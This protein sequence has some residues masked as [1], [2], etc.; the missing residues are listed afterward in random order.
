SGEPKTLTLTLDEFK[1]TARDI[2]YQRM[3]HVGHGHEDVEFYERLL[4]ED[5]PVD[6]GDPN[7]DA[8]RELE[9]TSEMVV[10][11]MERLA[12]LPLVGVPVVARDEA[13]ELREENHT[14]RT[15]ADGWLKRVELLEAAIREWAEATSDAEMFELDQS[16]AYGTDH[17]DAE[18]RVEA[19]AQAL[20]RLVGG[21]NEK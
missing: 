12:N 8:L 9:D 13:A 2:T 14:L 18:D 16:N 7:H 11:V 15:E 20:R 6:E 3:Q 4:D 17:A 21:E 19:A 1:A 10:F 5:T